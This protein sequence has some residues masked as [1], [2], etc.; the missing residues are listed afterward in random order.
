M[1]VQILDRDFR[2][3]AQSRNLRCI[4]EYAHNQ[5]WCGVTKLKQE[6]KTLHVHFPGGTTCTTLFQ[7]EKVL[8]TWIDDRVRFGRGK[9]EKTSP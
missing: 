3:V 2:V 9:F 5:R 1:N 7:S 8:T 4:G 6:G